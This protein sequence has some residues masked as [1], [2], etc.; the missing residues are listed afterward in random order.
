MDGAKKTD[1]IFPNRKG[2]KIRQ[3]SKAYNRA[4]DDLKLNK[5][6]KDQRDKVVA[7]TWR[8]TFASWLTMEGVPLPTVQKLLGH[9][10]LEMTLRYSHLS[11]SH[12][13][14]AVEKISPGLL[15]LKVVPIKKK[16][17]K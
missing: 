14:E 15:E 7:H 11:P 2:E 4:V 12:E 8:H 5:G 3:L 16:K 17:R 9:Q 6:V 13:R 1:L 10:S